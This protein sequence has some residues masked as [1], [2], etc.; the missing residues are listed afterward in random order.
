[1]VY[2]IGGIATNQHLFDYY[3]P[4]IPGAVYLPFPRHDAK[5]TMTTYVQKFLPLIDTKQAFTLVGNSMGGIMAMELGCYLRPE[6]TIL[7]SS[8]KNRH[9]MP[10]LL[11]QLQ[12]T[13]LHQLMPGQALIKGIEI[14]SRFIGEINRVPGLRKLVVEMA[15]SNR[16]DFLHWC[17][18]AIVQWQ[19]PDQYGKVIHLHGTKDKLFPIEKIHDPVPV[20]GGTHYMILNKPQEVLAKLLKALER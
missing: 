8:I 9:E 1:M 6:K 16:P 17:V 4:H 11:K 15:R 5:D 7:I 20:I 14:G 10:L 19:G 12:F 13:R 3:F 18:N 2:F